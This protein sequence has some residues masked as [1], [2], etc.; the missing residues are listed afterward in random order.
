[1]IMVGSQTRL[2]VGKLKDQRVAEEIANRLSVD[3]G[4]LST[5]CDFEELWSALKTTVLDIAGECLGTHRRGKKNLVSQGTLDTIDHSC[6]VRL[7]GRAELFRELRCKTVRA[8]RVD[9]EAD[10]FRLCEGVEQHL[11]SSDS[12]PACRG[13]HTLRSSK[14]IPR[15]TAV[16]AKS[17]ELLTEESKVKAR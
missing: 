5:L 8:L 13:M 14:P 12:N 10:V 11:W 15:C 6:K 16:R 3:F 7:N 17:G 1:M 2:N 4:V 9:R